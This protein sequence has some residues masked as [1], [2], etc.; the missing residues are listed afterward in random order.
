[1]PPKN[2]E[3]VGA[4]D[5]DQAI[6]LCPALGRMA[7]EEPDQ[8]L[9]LHELHQ[10]SVG[11]EQPTETKAAEAA[12]QDDIKATAEQSLT[13]PP[14][15]TSVINQAYPREAILA[16]SVESIVEVKPIPEAT[17]IHY[18]EQAIK[19]I[20]QKPAVDTKVD[21]VEPETYLKTTDVVEVVNLDIYMPAPQAYEIHEESPVVQQEH[22]VPSNAVEPSPLT[23]NVE[24]VTT[25]EIEVV[26]DTQVAEI[27]PVIEAETNVVE[28]PL[29]S[30]D[31]LVESVEEPPLL[32]EVD[33][34]VQ[35]QSSEIPLT[36]VLLPQDT[37]PE[38][39]EAA[40]IEI[41]PVP[42]TLQMKI[43]EL[44]PT[45]SEEELIVLHEDIE[46]L[47]E[48]V[49]LLQEAYSEVSLSPEEILELE[50]DVIAS[51]CKLSE[52]FGITPTPALITE[53]LEGIKTNAEHKQQFHYKLEEV[54]DES[55]HESRHGMKG[56]VKDFSDT[57]RGSVS[58]MLGRISMSRSLA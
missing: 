13:N 35:P 17:F 19:A 47:T 28:V 29:T 52:S 18:E 44:L 48:Q 7:I 41:I 10:L 12:L 2:H 49:Q 58:G 34:E 40:V 27:N 55:A 36:E 54:V 32:L 9:A 46:I 3:A 6:K 5:F 1:M 11:V 20:E 57:F 56:F 51:F 16:Q 38:K 33:A 23:A 42:P 39:I 26:T 24:N 37:L 14:L 22:H 4:I 30:A 8:A 50:E 53:F 43:L 45:K 21:K 31:V 25:E 15:S